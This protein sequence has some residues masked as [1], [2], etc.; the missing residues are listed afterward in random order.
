MNTAGYV[1]SMASVTVDIV[2]DASRQAVWAALADIPSHVDWM[3]DAAAI[4]FVSSQRE[5]AGTSFDCD[6]RIGPIRLV[7]RMEITEWEPGRVFGVRHKGVVTGVGRFTL[8]D[9][10]PTATRLTWE[11]DL[12]FPAWLG[13]RLGATA[14]RTVLRRIWTGNLRRFRSRLEDDT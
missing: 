7:D 8:R 4:R 9:E 6:T 12:Q 13:G 3:M 1:R 5:G 2:I 10:G 14:A 11:E